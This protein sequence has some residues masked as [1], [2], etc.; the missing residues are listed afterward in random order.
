MAQR[1]EIVTQPTVEPITLDEA[2]LHLRVSITDDDAL[3][4][5]LIKAAR[6][7]CEARLRRAICTQTIDCYY[8]N[9]PWGGGYYN[10]MIRQAGPSPYWLPTSTGIMDLPRPPVQSVTGVYYLD[11]NGT[12]QAID[13]TL[14]TYSV[15]TPG[16]LQPVFGKVWPIA[17]PT[18][19][20]VRIRM[21]VG[22]G[23]ASAVPDAIKAAM[24]LM[25]GTWYENREDVNIGNIASVIPN[26]ADL[27]LSTEDWGGYA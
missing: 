25:I 23:D 22:Y 15:G 24:K 5:S 26:T 21:I 7:V 16:R 9:F 20:A 1:T 18:I 10:R 13:P 2:K 11:Y 19:D 6:S 12:Y 3:I 27:L 14:Y 8:D 17:R 4:T